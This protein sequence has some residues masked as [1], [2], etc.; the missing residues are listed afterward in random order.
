MKRFILI[1]TALFAS[2]LFL[3]AQEI[4]R[5]LQHHVDAR[6][7]A[8]IETF[9]VGIDYAAGYRF[10]NFI[11]AGFGSG[12]HQDIYFGGYR[13]AQES[14]FTPI[15]GKVNKYKYSGKGNSM[16]YRLD[17]PKSHIP[18]YANA[19]FYMMRTRLAPYIGI[20]AGV[21]LS[22]DYILPYG[23]LTLGGRHITKRN[24]EWTFGFSFSYP[25]YHGHALAG[26][27]QSDDN[28]DGVS[29][30]KA[31]YSFWESYN[32]SGGLT[33]GYSF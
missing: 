12:Y 21:D 16:V 6:Y 11:F 14:E 22:K 8:T 10:N 18:L 20:S 24:R 23:N 27:Y 5:G 28:H 30:S 15:K 29:T 32:L 31:E 26:Y 2:F 1:T 7:E 4:N 9:I 3:E 19:R 17:R 13:T 33:I 25:K